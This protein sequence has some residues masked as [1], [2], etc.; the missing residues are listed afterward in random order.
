MYEINSTSDCA[1]ADCMS[2]M[3]ASA[4]FF[5][6]GS[7]F[8]YVALKSS[9]STVFVNNAFNVHASFC[10]VRFVTSYVPSICSIALRI[11]SSFFSKVTIMIYLYNTLKKLCID[12][13]L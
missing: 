5:T 3:T 10:C 1:L 7:S 12:F 6:I 2:I 11:S 9:D 13:S 4:C 8:S